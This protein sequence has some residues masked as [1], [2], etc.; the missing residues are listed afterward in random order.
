MAAVVA[1]GIWENYLLFSPKMTVA[2]F[3]TAL[4]TMAK[5]N[6]LFGAEEYRGFT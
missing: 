1:C 5:L 6:I 4:K 3:K 2:Q